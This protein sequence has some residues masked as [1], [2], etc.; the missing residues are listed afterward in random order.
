M[1]LSMSEETNMAPSSTPPSPTTPGVPPSATKETM[2]ESAWG[3]PLPSER[4]V[5]PAMAGG[6]PSKRARPSR[7]EQK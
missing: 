1:T 6:R 2:A 5:A 4:S 3:A 7:L